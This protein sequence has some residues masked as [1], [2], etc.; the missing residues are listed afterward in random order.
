MF[1]RAFIQVVSR[2]ARLITT[3]TAPRWANTPPTGSFTRFYATTPNQDALDVKIAKAR[4]LFDEGTKRWNDN[5]IDG[6]EQHMKSKSEEAIKA[7]QKCLEIEPSQID[8]HVNL[9][10]VYA[11]FLKSPEKALGHYKIATE[12]NPEDGEVQYNY[13]VVLD[14]MGKLEEAIVQYEKSVANGV[15]QANK[16]LRNARAKLAGKKAE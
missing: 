13:G 8:A 12:I 9:A 11:I 6:H 1:K 7:W 3:V 15:D 4:E 16:N 14:S 5:D 2:R 10:N